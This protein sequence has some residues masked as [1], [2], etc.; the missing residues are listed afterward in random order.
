MATK[1]KIAEATPE[2]EVTKV[3]ANKFEVATTSRRMVDKAGLI[4]EIADLEG[5]IEK[6]RQDTG[7]DKM[8]EA[9]ADKQALLSEL[10]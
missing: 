7:L 8:E 6:L 10:K 1:T 2:R 3:T 4:Q 5:A 9:L